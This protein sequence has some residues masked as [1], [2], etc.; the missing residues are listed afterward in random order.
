MTRPAIGFAGMTHLGVNSA[1][2][3]AARGFP[4]VWFDPE[5]AQIERLE[6]GELPVVEP[7]L[8]DLVHKHRDRI[9]H[10]ADPKSLREC[11]VVY[12]ACDVPTDECGN[13]DLARVRDLFHTIAADLARD[14]VLVVL[15]QVPP[16]FT[17]SLAWPERQRY[18][19]VETLVFGRAVERAMHPERFIVGCAEPSAALPAP[20]R[21]LLEAFGCP[22]LPMRYESAELA[23]IAI[24]CCL[25]ASVTVSNTLAELSERIGADWNEVGPA[26]RLD[27]RIGQHAYLSPGLGLSGG[28]LERDLATVLRLA[29]ETGAEAGLIRSFADNSRHRRDWVLRTLHR[30]VLSGKHDAVIAVLGLAYK[31]NTDSTKNSAALALI[32]HLQPWRLQIHDPVVHARAVDHPQTA[33]FA[34]PL[35]TAAQADALVITTPWPEYRELAADELACRMRGRVIVDP[36]RVLDGRAAVAEGFDYFTLGVPALRAAAG[37]ATRA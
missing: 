4:T 31:E 3:A 18:Y 11:A 5:R 23:K 34:T 33:R 30:E 17:R 29:G 8:A 16:G 35:E 7:G 26:L 13:S 19:Q 28:N 24:N 6:R 21:T 1:A 14:A 32:R 10:A 2:A 9:R 22:I 36:F 15:C 25:V 27:R 37:K 12:I 20:Y